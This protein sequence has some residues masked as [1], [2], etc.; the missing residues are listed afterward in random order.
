MC[1]AVPSQVIEIQGTRGRVSV[2]GMIRE[3]SLML[4]DEVQVG[5]YV[6]VH[7]GFAISRM[8]ADAARET[9]ADLRGL[10][11]KSPPLPDPA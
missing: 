10:L 6:I 3:A 4:L 2:D 7:A 1:L 8:D 9:L 5:D 11:D